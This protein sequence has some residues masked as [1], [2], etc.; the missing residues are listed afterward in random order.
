MEPSAS[1]SRRQGPG[2]RQLV[3]KLNSAPLVAKVALF[4]A[5]AAA[6]A[7]GYLLL[8]PSST[9][10]SVVTENADDLDVSVVEPLPSGE[11][12]GE[13]SFQGGASSRTPLEESGASSRGQEEPEQA[14]CTIFV[15][16]GGNDAASGATE[17]EALRSPGAA[18]DRAGPGDVVCFAPGI[19]SS[20]SR[21]RGALH[22]EGKN[23]TAEAPIVFRSVDP[24]ARAVF[25]MGGANDGR[26]VSVVFVQRSSHLV[27][28][29]IEATNGFRGF[30]INGSNNVQ[31]LRSHIHN[32][33]GELVYVGKRAGRVQPD[34]GNNPASFNVLIEGNEI[35]HSGLAD[36]FGEGIYVATSER[37]Y[38][39]DTNNVTIRNNIIH[40]VKDEA[41]DVKTGG[42][43]VS[44]VDNQIYNVDLHSQG[45]ITVPLALMPWNDG[46]RRQPIDY[47]ML[48]ILR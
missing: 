32:T 2:W 10:N 12:I 1:P 11:L 5:G 47:P 3:E 46:H 44:I 40:D 41:I 21:N 9:G 22:I 20:G 25:S 48:R 37:E 17:G 8:T 33:G 19:Y 23:G 18:V 14:P 45:A 29:G 42:Y 15:A 38:G 13:E 43:A 26:G 7:F 39:D 4:A 6:I 30:T 31:L 34:A 16:T 24:A 35:A 28:D 27:F 36:S